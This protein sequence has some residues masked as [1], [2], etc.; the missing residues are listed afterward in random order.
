[1]AKTCFIYFIFMFCLISF[2]NASYLKDTDRKSRVE[3]AK[4]LLSEIELIDALIP[5][6][7]PSQKEWYEK[8][9]EANRKIYSKE[10]ANRLAW[11]VEYHT[12]KIKGILKNL[13][14]YLTTILNKNIH[15]KTEVYFWAYVVANMIRA[16]IP[17][18]NIDVLEDNK[19]VVINA[20]VLKR[21]GLH[22]V[23][24]SRFFGFGIQAEK[25]QFDIVIAY[26]SDDLKE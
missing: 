11:C 1:M 5:N 17:N 24:G 19:I 3:Y 15:L 16:E 14:L 8:E 4:A 26:L 13:K 10:R 6:L 18:E 21:T 12:I 25:I 9:R 2:A 7:K 22:Y 20:K 23:K